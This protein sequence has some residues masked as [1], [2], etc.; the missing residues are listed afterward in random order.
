MIR[1]H[2]VAAA[3]ALA[4]LGGCAGVRPPVPEEARV[5]APDGW[6][7]ASTGNAALTSN[8]WESF[9]DPDLTRVVQTALAHNDDVQLAAARIL[10]VEAQYGYTRAQQGP[11]LV[12]GA[13]AVRERNVNPGFGVPEYQT[14]TESLLSLSFDADLFGR[15]ASASDAAKASL[16]ATRAARANIQLDVAAASA[17]TYLTL[18]SLDERLA[19]LQR[20]LDARTQSLQIMRRRASVGYSSQLELAQAEAELRAT[21]QLIPTTKLAIRRSEDAL[22]VLLGQTPAA[23]VR[24]EGVALPNVPSLPSALPSSLLRRR[25]DIVAAEDRLVAADH[26]LDSARA[27][28]MPDLQLS[29]S[30]GSVTSSLIHDSPLAIFSLGGSLLAPIFDSGRLKAQQETVAARRDEAAFAYRKATLQAFSEVEDALAA[31]QRIRE[32]STSLEGQRV[33]LQRNLQIATSRYRAGYSPYLDQLDAQRGLLGVELS[34]ARS[35]A[36]EL[37]ACVALFQALGGGWD[38]S[39]IEP[40]QAA[41]KIRD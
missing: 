17:R 3:A 13:A 12:G 32:Q 33:A 38:R 2:V 23:I 16:L 37:I 25:P 22:N 6:R 31:N 27:A 1:R 4:L 24:P 35:R 28:F 29:G 20:T 5:T 14:A 30:Y 21:E 41:N 9:G 8:W 36:D 34:L 18:R 19:I 11:N 7:T 39:G 15:L 26:A 10:E 40:V